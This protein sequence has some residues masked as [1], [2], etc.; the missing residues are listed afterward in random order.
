MNVSLLYDVVSAIVNEF[1]LEVRL[2][3]VLKHF[4]LGVLVGQSCLLDDI[5][6]ALA[7][8][9]E[10]SSQ[11]RRLQRFLDNE[12]VEIATLQCEWARV[13]MHTIKSG[14]LILLV[15]ETTL[16]DHLKAMV[17]GIWTPDGCIPI[18]WQCYHPKAYPTCGQVSL[19]VGLV[20]RILPALPI[21]L[22]VRLLADRGIG[23]SPDLI[24]QIDQLGIDILF[25]VQGTTRFRYPNGHT[26]S[27]RDLGIKGQT[28][29]SA[30]DVFKK[31]NWIGLHAA[32]LWGNDYEE[33]WCLV[34]SQPIDPATY[35]LRFDQEV[36]FR[37]LK[38]DGFQWHRSHVW[39]PDHAERLLLVLVIAY[40]LVLT[41]G[42]ALPKPTT[43][44][45]ARWST[46]R[47]G[48][49]AFTELFRPTIALILPPPPLPPP[50]I[51]CVVQ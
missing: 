8:L 34:S 41:T 1:S 33:P 6:H 48:L 15:D 47:L 49:E 23:T 19:I 2:R 26:A 21:P 38:S 5:A 45:A 36:S 4:I 37:D 12:R 11:Y 7:P 35:R 40:W 46:F 27:L 43:G 16:S 29:Q 17:L 42:Q 50:R 39:L 28:W 51:T 13:V 32:V 14:S 10:V 22:S 18:A 44:R 31:A 3:R 20:N 30:G 24:R 25:R 9:G